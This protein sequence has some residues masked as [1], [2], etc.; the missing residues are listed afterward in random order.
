MPKVRVARPAGSGNGREGTVSWMRSNLL[1]EWVFATNGAKSDILLGLLAR[2][3][4]LGIKRLK[5][6]AE[7]A[8][9][10][11][12]KLVVPGGCAGGPLAHVAGHAD[13]AE[14]TLVAFWLIVHRTPVVESI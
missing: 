7:V 11:H 6:R 14:R 5:C 1:R 8:A 10:D 2:L 12:A 13:N 3:G 4:H 9:F